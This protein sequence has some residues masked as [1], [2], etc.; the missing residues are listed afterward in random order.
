MLENQ[1]AAAVRPSSSVGAVTFPM[2]ER[3]HISG[4]KALSDDDR[5]KHLKAINKHRKAIDE[6]SAGASRR[7]FAQCWTSRLMTTLLIEGEEDDD[8]AFLVELQKLAEQAEAL[9]IT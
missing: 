9:A 5:A 6:T 1:A 4:V 3:A 2:N 7:I 8:K